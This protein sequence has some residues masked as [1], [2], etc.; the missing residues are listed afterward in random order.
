[1]VECNGEWNGE[2]NQMIKLITISLCKRTDAFR[3]NLCDLWEKAETPSEGR[4]VQKNRPGPER[5]QSP[6]AAQ[7]YERCHDGSRQFLDDVGVILPKRVDSEQHRKPHP[8]KPAT[9]RKIEDELS[10]SEEPC[11]SGS[12]S[13]KQKLKEL[14]YPLLHEDNA[15]IQALKRYTKD[16]GDGLLASITPIRRMLGYVQF[17]AEDKSGSGWQ[18]LLD[19]ERM[20]EYNHLLRGTGASPSTAKNYCDKILTVMKLAESY[21]FDQPG[22]PTDPNDHKAYMGNL[23]KSMI[24]MR[25]FRDSRKLER[26]RDLA[27]KRAQLGECL[28]DVSVWEE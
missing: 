12:K 11:A 18:L 15:V 25:K 19:T 7:G 5:G 26:E 10:E 6:V 8:P 21:F 9:K 17:M 22:M 28:P 16:V 2:C 14:G 24:R 27:D 23:K 1:M 13:T 3:M 20:T 4:G